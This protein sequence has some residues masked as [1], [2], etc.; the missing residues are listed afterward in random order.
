[1]ANRPILY[2]AHDA[3]INNG[4]AV[5]NKR[6][7][8]NDSPFEIFKLNTENNINIQLYYCK[9]ILYTKI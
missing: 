8:I 7:S 1:M 6:V 3:A 2:K 5:T 4:T 9:L